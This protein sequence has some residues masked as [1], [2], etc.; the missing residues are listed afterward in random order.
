MRRQDNPHPA[1]SK[2]KSLE[3]G[4]QSAK[5]KSRKSHKPEKGSTPKSKRKSLLPTIETLLNTASQPGVNVQKDSQLDGPFTNCEELGLLVHSN[6]R[7]SQ[8][9]RAL[10]ILGEIVDPDGTKPAYR[11]RFRNRLDL[12]VTTEIPFD[13]VQAPSNLFNFAMQKGLLDE[14]DNPKFRGQMLRMYLILNCQVD[15]TYIRVRDKGLTTLPDGSECYCL[16][17]EVTGAQDGKYRAVA[18]KGNSTDIMVLPHNSESE[19]TESHTN[20]MAAWLALTSA[21]RNDL[22]AVLVVCAA[23]ASVLLKHTHQSS[24]ALIL[25]GKS[26]IGKSVLLWIVSALFMRRPCLVTWD[27]TDNGL[28]ATTTEKRDQP[29]AVDELGQSNGAQVARMAYRAMNGVGR[30]RADTTGQAKTIAITRSVMLSAGEVSP[31][32]LMRQSQQGIYKGQEARFLTIPVAEPHGVWTQLGDFSSGADKSDWIKQQITAFQGAPGRELLQHVVPVLS[33]LGA[34]F[35][36]DRSELMREIAS[37][38][39]FDA[40]DAVQGR[41]LDSFAL[42]AF[43]GKIAH[44]YG[45]VDWTRTEIMAAIC[46]GFALWHA[47]YL[48]NQPVNAGILIQSVR[49]FLQSERGN[50]IKPLPE[51]ADEHAGVL[52]GFEHVYRKGEAVFLLYPSYFNK[53]LCGKYPPEQVLAALKNA[54]LLITGPRGVPTRQVHMPGSDDERRSFYVVS[55]AILQ[56]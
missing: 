29:L 23:F 31:F 4:G 9:C 22:L 34:Q 25:V 55:K 41:V 33:E 32:G 52:A 38:T 5:S 53:H 1:A 12:E 14:I 18:V 51:W 47:E 20:A 48:K 30:Q 8:I 26:S 44:R 50:R 17:G 16:D 11:V 43:A 6:G 24:K 56:G 15:H 37:A 2:R 7:N 45:V 46:H 19:A 36:N 21:L 27:T 54:G 42:F 3:S 49:V 28:E 10:W 39:D 40:T 13:V 35:Q